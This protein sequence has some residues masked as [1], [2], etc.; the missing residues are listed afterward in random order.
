MPTAQG[1][2]LE[3]FVSK[4]ENQA[5]AYQ[6]TNP[7]AMCFPTDAD[8]L[9]FDGRTHNFVTAEERA[10]LN[11]QLTAANQSTVNGKLSVSITTKISGVTASSAQTLEIGSPA[12]TYEV[13]V[14]YGGSAIVPTNISCSGSASSLSST[15][16]AGVYTAAADQKP[17][18]RLTLSV[19]ANYRTTEYGGLTASKSASSVSI[20]YVAAVYIIESAVKITA[21]MTAA[22][23]NALIDSGNVIAKHLITSA[24]SIGKINIS[25]RDAN[26]YIYVL[27]PTLSSNGPAVNDVTVSDNS[28]VKERVAI[29]QAI[30]ANGASVNYTAVRLT[31]LCASS[32]EVISGATFK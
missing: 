1:Q 22:Q 23:V 12:P 6:S 4:T 26:R 32:G 27:H 21:D 29:D 28:I 31:E 13:S 24:S 7:G 17:A 19:S 2:K 3:I 18:G 16:R 20:T 30:S 5:Q 15:G 11:S 8:S 10:Y 14:S 9:V 25:A